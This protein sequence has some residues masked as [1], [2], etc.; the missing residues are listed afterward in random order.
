MKSYY[1]FLGGVIVGALAVGIP[2]RLRQQPANEVVAMVDD[3]TVTRTNA[4][5]SGEPL[6]VSVCPLQSAVSWQGKDGKTKHTLT[7][8]SSD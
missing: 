7:Q 6:Y 5:D 3:C 4:K 8:N 1:L 2:N